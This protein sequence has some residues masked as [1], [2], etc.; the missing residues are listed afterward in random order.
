MFVRTCSLLLLSAFFLLVALFCTVWGALTFSS[1]KFTTDV[2]VRLF[3]Q[4]TQIT[5]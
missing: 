2:K 5:Q 3:L 1:Y 4:I